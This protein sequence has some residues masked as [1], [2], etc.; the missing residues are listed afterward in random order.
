[1]IKVNERG[2]QDP[3]SKDTQG[4]SE[5]MGFL[6]SGAIHCDGDDCVRA[7]LFVEQKSMN[8][9]LSEKQTLLL[10]MIDLT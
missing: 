5:L 10:T 6:F 7:R 2:T 3:L 4:L 9:S 1:L 8:Q